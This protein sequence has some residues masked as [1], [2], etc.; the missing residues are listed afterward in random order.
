[1]VGI[2]ENLLHA[3]MFQNTKPP[4]KKRAA[5]KGEEAL[6]GRVGERLKPRS[7]ARGEQKGLARHHFQMR[8]LML[9]MILL[10]S[11]SSAIGSSRCPFKA[12]RTEERRFSGA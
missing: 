3:E 2:D 6:R 10:P 11:G 7:L 8:R 9:K 12:A 1:M 5:A 4:I